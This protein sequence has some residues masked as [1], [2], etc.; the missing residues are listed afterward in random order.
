MMWSTAAKSE[1]AKEA[2][3]Q[4]KK[5]EEEMMRGAVSA[6]VCAL[7]R[8]CMYL[9]RIMTNP[10]LK[11]PTRWLRSNRASKVVSGIFSIT[12]HC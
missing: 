3:R 5:A 9:L 4:K 12:Y 8:G 1:A 10:N 6:L 7:P 2:A 11:P